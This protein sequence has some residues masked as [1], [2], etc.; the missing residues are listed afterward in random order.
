M[1]EELS[2]TPNGLVFIQTCTCIVKAF[3]LEE[4][5]VVSS[6]DK[7]SN[8]D[9]WSERPTPLQKMT[10]KGCEF[11]SKVQKKAGLDCKKELSHK[12]LVVE[13][14]ITESSNLEALRSA[15]QVPK[16]SADKTMQEFVNWLNLKRTRRR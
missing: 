16:N 13:K 5:F 15:L 6:V 2:E 10:K 11:I 4:Y 1:S 3:C 9:Q 7:H 12:L 14:L 8:L